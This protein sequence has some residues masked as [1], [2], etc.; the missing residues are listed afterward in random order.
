M[1]LGEAGVYLTRLR[2]RQRQ[3]LGELHHLVECLRLVDLVADDQHGTPRLDE[4]LRCPLHFHRVRP[5]THPGIDLIVPDDFGRELLL[6]EV[7]VPVHVRRTIGRRPGH[8]EGAAHRLGNLPG[9]TCRP[10]ELR[11]RLGELFL[12]G[13]LLEAVASGRKRFLSPVR[14]K[15]ERRLLFPRV[16]HLAE[17]VRQPDDGSLHDDGGLTGG[18][19]VAGGHRGARSLVRREDVLELRPIDERLVEVRVLACRVAEDVFDA[20]G[21]ELLGEVLATRARETGEW[22]RA[23]PAPPAP[24]PLR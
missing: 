14:I 13:Q 23:K 17:R 6:R 12:S 15:D 3:K 10:R 1:L 5:D 7:G 2:D 22:P 4:E 18:F 21:N 24:A 20:R 11:H 8:A 19:H 9:R 16:E